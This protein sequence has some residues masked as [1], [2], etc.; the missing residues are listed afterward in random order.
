MFARSTVALLLGV[1]LTVAL[2]APAMAQ[3][4]P[5]DPLVTEP[6]TEAPAGDG[7]VIAPEDPTE[8]VTPPNDV[9]ANTG[10]DV[11]VWVAVAYVLVALGGGLLLLA[12]ALDLRPLPRGRR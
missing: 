9:M 6:G 12:H 2:A 11:S 5:F 3:R 7:T 8:P 4:D 1:L 10:A